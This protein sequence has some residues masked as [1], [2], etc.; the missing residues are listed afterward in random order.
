MYSIELIEKHH[1][2]KEY[3]LFSRCSGVQGKR[4]GGQM[5][6]E[7]GGQGKR[8]GRWTR[9]ED[10]GQG[11]RMGRQTREDRWEKRIEILWGSGNIYL[12]KSWT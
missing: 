3:I 10:G 1:I 9:E 11:K 4:M 8:T 12:N 2:I 5:R 7:D 6:E